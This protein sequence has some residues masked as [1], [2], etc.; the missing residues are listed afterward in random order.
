VLRDLKKQS[1]FAPIHAAWRGRQQERQASALQAEYEA[2]G[3]ANG[4]RPLSRPELQ[5]Q[6][7]QRLSPRRAG[8]PAKRRGQMHTMVIYGLQN[9]EA[10]L[11]RSLEP[12]G[13][14]TT[15]DWRSRGFEDRTEGWVDRRDAMNVAMLDAFRQAN[16]E[17]PIDAVVGYVAGSTTAPETLA[18]MAAEGAAIFNFCWDDKLFFPG[19]ELGGRL[20]SP[21]P[22]ASTIDLNLTNA[23]SSVIKYA[24]H[25]GLAMFW[26]EAAHPA[27]HRPYETPFEFDV[28]FV[29]Q[30]YGNRPRFV[31]RLQEAGINVQTF[32]RGW[33][34]GPLSDEEMVRLYSR[35]RINLGFGQIGFA[36]NL[37]CLKGRDFEVPMSGGLYLTQHNPELALVYD[38]DREIRTW[39]NVHECIHQIRTLLAD[40]DRA[41][42]IRS[43]GRARALRD[44]TYDARYTEIFTL[45]GLLEPSEERS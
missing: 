4:Y 45:A 38:L 13:K 32:G 36:P 15:F 8:R 28:S 6:V 11:P 37:M 35:S 39:R 22:L 14:V 10:I 12:F 2:W 41:A 44:H 18:A 33:A 25:G 16:R 7:R 42:Q 43:A 29:G 30:R 9:W 34:N 17:Q 31:R 40:P 21:A 5:D 26:P 20:T 23:P 3:R 1:W 24:R 19:R 27:V